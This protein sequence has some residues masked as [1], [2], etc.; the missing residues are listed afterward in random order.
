MIT[1]IEQM[2]ALRALP[3]GGDAPVRFELP[4]LGRFDLRQF[5][6]DDSTVR[7]LRSRVRYL[8]ALFPHTPI[9]PLAEALHAVLDN[10][11]LTIADVR[12][13]L[14]GRKLNDSS[15]L[16]GEVPLAG[17]QKVGEVLAA[18]GSRL[19]AAR[20]SGLSID[21]VEAIDN[22]LG[23]CEKYNERMLDLAIRAVQDG[24]S[25]RQFSERSGLPK[26]SAH[27]KMELARSVMREIGANV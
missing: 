25:V 5:T 27:R 1:S 23:L 6:S 16:T 7:S 13:I 17:I 24:L 4:Y 14:E 2:N 12:A 11:D 3:V 8:A 22:Y 19:K 9:V 21:S 10:R 18:G 26:T 20:E 15:Q